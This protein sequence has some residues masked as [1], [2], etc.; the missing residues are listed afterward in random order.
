MLSENRHLPDNFVEDMIFKSPSPDVMNKLA[1]SVL[2]LY[3]YD[4]NADDI[5]VE[6]VLRQ[7]IELVAKLPLLMSYAY[8]A[9]R[10]YIDKKSLYI[11]FPLPE[12][13]TAQNIL[14][15]I[16]PNGTFTELEARTTQ[17]GRA[18]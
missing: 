14:R 7:S 18:S 5:S 11:R 12:Y 8:M 1:R 16:R 2:A 10:H 9:K 17:I 3:S 6:N 13:S 4:A 15:L